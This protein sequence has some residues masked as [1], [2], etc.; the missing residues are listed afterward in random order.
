MDHWYVGCGLHP[1]VPK[2]ISAVSFC[3][4][5]E[6]T[7]LQTLYEILKFSSNILHHKSYIEWWLSHGESSDNCTNPDWIYL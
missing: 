7:G 2:Y 6:D 4:C 3:D 1:T 5:V